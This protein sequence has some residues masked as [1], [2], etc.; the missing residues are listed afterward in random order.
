M[1]FEFVSAGN[2]FSEYR[3]SACLKNIVV[4]DEDHDPVACPHCGTRRFDTP[5]KPAVVSVD[6]ASGPD[7]TAVSVAPE[8]SRGFREGMSETELAAELRSVMSH[9]R[10]AVAEIAANSL[11]WE[12]II[13]HGCPVS[14]DSLPAHSPEKWAARI[15]SKNGT[16]LDVRHGATMK[17]AVDAAMAALESGQAIH[18]A[19]VG[20]PA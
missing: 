15:R 9:F 4:H 3:C 13:E 8:F 20:R 14:N 10:P 17:E 6:L 16:V 2:T 18:D 19:V 1:T 11:R 5:S 7:E 12:F